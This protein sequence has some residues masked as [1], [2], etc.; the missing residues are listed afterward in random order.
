[1]PHDCAKFKYAS[2]QSLMI[3]LGDS[4]DIKTHHRVLKL[5][6]MMEAK[7][8]QG[9]RN[10]HPGYCSLL[11]VFDPLRQDHQQLE[12]K[13][14]SYIDQFGKMK[15]PVPPTVEIPVCYG[16]ECGPDLL[17][18]ADHHGI[19]P[20]RVI[21]LHSDA[22]YFV[23]FVGF[24]PGFA[25]LGGLPPELSTPRLGTPRQKVPVGSVAIGGDHTGVYPIETPGGWRLIGKT[26]LPIFDRS[27]PRMS[28]L[29]IGDRVR[30]TPIMPQKFS[31]QQRRSQ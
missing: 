4:V 26:P 15:L 1:M 16:G 22:E 23:Y 3:Y 14:S 9:V 8:I 29:S 31:G 13:I 12:K 28:C 11:V 20:E 6:R 19:S 2:D 25:Y 24:V 5:L 27:L 30:F 10:L 21:K 17:D 18:L 7:P